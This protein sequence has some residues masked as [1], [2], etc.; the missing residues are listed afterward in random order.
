[1]R[2]K[3][4]LEHRVTVNLNQEQHLKLQNL[5]VKDG[6]PVA[7]IIRQAVVN[8]LKDKKVEVSNTTDE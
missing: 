6:V 5:S 4:K 7:L 8:Y 3:T 1:M 2:D